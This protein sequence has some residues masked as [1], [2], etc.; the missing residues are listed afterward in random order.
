[1]L[2]GTSVA[3]RV[4]LELRRVMLERDY[5]PNLVED[6]QVA[7]DRLIVHVLRSADN[8]AA[9][10]ELSVLATEMV[11]YAL[12]AAETKGWSMRE[13]VGGANANQS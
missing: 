8:Q 1:M 5:N 11:D 13:L 3:V 12:I 6:M 10:D 7:C 2:K 4:G 9:R